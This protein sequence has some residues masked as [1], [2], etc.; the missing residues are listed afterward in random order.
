[1]EGKNPFSI[2]FSQ[3]DERYVQGQK[4]NNQATQISII[5]SMVPSVSYNF[6]F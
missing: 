4:I 6:K 1:M 3:A 2:Y 5:G